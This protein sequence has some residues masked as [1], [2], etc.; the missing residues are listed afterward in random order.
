MDFKNSKIVNNKEKFIEFLEKF[1]TSCYTGKKEVC[2]PSK[3]TLDLRNKY[4]AGRFTT[5]DHASLYAKDYVKY[6]YKNEMLFYAICFI[7]E[8]TNTEI[9]IHKKD[10]AFEFIKTSALFEE[11][12]YD[13]PDFDK[14]YEKIR[15]IILEKSGYDIGNKDSKRESND[16]KLIYDIQ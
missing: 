11:Q 13:S 9:V 15:K 7:D 5:S 14:T 4:R 8:S 12:R 1:S 6:I 2:I 10:L 3:I 16:K